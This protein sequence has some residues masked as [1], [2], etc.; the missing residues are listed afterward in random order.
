M[1]ETDFSNL[2]RLTE[3]EIEPAAETLA[4]A[5]HDYPTFVYFFPDAAERKEKSPLLCPF[6]VR[7]GILYGEVY[8]TSPNL[9]GVAIWLPSDKADSTPEEAVRA[10]ILPIIPKIGQDALDRLVNVGTFLNGIHK[11]FAPLPHHF[12]QFIGV[13]PEFQGKGYASAL[14]KPMLARIDGESLPCYLDTED[15]KN[16]A[17]YQRYGFKVVDE[18]IMPGTEIRSWAMLREKSA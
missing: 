18:A 1:R 3:S 14:L 2:V 7:F 4:R 8:A 10:G 17:I 15:E 16:V 13:D 6:F 12:L 9:E 5:F 11:V